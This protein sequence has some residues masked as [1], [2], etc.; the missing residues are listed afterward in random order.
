MCTDCNHAKKKQENPMKIG[1][2]IVN[3]SYLSKKPFQTRTTEAQ[4]KQIMTNSRCIYHEP[5]AMIPP[6]QGESDTI[7]EYTQYPTFPI[8]PSR[9]P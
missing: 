2:A 3:I 1:H 5:Y 8:L 4:G 7:C 9:I 6:G